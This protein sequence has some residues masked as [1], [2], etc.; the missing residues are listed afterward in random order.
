MMNQLIAPLALISL[1][2]AC[3]AGESTSE[4]S[5]PANHGIEQVAAPSTAPDLQVATFAGG[6]FWCME[7]PF[8]ELPGVSAVVSGYTAGEKQFPTYKEVCTGSTGHAEAVQVHFDASQVPYATLLDVFWRQIDPTDAGGQ[9]VDRGTQYRPAIYYD[10]EAQKEIALRSRAA[11]QAS[12]RFD[13]PIATEIEPL[14]EFF[15]AEDN[16][17]DYYDKNPGNYKRYRKGSGR[18][19]FLESAW[20]A[21][22]E[23]KPAKSAVRYSKPDDATLR[24]R[25]TELQYEVT[26]KDGTERSFKNEYWDNKEAGI[27]VDIVSGEPLFS[28]QEKYKS[29]TGWP[30]F[31]KPLV[32]ENIALDKDY[33]IGYARNEVRSKHGNSHLGHVFDD[34][35]EPT[36]LRYCMNSAALRFI[37]VA[38]LEQEGYGEFLAKFK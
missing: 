14:T 4:P 27:Y 13:K 35:P 21:D 23:L 19:K 3:T 16:H 28:S 20:G 1:L 2:A 9:F 7:L 5:T 33:K 31:W 26:Q 22:L 25:L 36:G 32:A 17:Q 18:D 15:P 30:S 12:G 6:C 34:G 11:L 8:E 10:G 24:A 38:D 29:G 37:P